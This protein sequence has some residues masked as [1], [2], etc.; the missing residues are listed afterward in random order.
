MKTIFQ[1]LSRTCGGWPPCSGYVTA[2]V[3]YNS[4][5]LHPPLIVVAAMA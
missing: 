1:E 4:R 3:S 5:F 2:G